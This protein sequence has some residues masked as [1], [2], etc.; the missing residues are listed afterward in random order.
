M[1]RRDGSRLEGPSDRVRPSTGIPRPED[2]T[3][4]RQQR[5]GKVA[6]DPRPLVSR[7][8]R[9]GARLGPRG[10]SP[11]DP[12][13]RIAAGPVVR[14][15]RLGCGPDQGTPRWAEDPSARRLVPPRGRCGELDEA[16]EE[17]GPLSNSP[18]SEKSLGLSF[19][20]HQ[21]NQFDFMSYPFDKV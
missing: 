4:S 18:S 12:P 14:H 10:L 1:L 11:L 3:A 7:G 19:T 5:R 20:C 15:L 16:A 9:G 13:P 2:K 17:P 21:G 6:A 8:D